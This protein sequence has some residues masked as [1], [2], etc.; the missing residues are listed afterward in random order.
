MA[1]TCG[2]IL[3]SNVLATDAEPMP[4]SDLALS[5]VTLMG[6]DPSGQL[7]ATHSSITLLEG[8]FIDLVLSDHGGLCGIRNDGALVCLHD[9]GQGPFEMGGDF[10]QVGG[11]GDAVKCAL[12]ADGTIAC[13]SLNETGFSPAYS[14][15]G[16]NFVRVVSGNNESCALTRPGTALC[17][18][19]VGPVTHGA[20]LFN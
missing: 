10:I 8:S 1:A 13:F 18:N 6:L 16:D 20:P 4:A 5:N 9:E 14:P 17:W 19:E 7:Q 3:V 12:G 15:P 2:G 11:S